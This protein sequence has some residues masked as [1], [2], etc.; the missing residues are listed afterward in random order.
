MFNRVDIWSLVMV[1]NQLPA[2]VAETNRGSTL[3]IHPWLIPSNMFECKRTMELNYAHRTEK[4]KPTVREQT[5]YLKV[6]EITIVILRHWAFR[7]DLDETERVV[8]AESSAARWNW[9][10]EIARNAN[11]WWRI[12]TH[13]CIVILERSQSTILDEDSRQNSGERR[14]F[15]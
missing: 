9:V 5:L 1:R 14:G 7:A 12:V 10:D 2:Q 6:F 15:K 3:S 4:T 13:A 8:R 11:S